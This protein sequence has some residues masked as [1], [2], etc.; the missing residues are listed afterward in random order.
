MRLN[1]PFETIIPNL[2]GFYGHKIELHQSMIDISSSFIAPEPKPGVDYAALAAEVPKIRA[3]LDYID[4]SA[5]QA[6]PLIFATLIDQKA[7]SKNHA[8]HLIITKAE[9]AELVGDITRNFG[10]KLDQKGQTFVV[11]AASVLKAHLLK[12]FKS[13]DD[14]WE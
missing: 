5:F 12:D 3:A 1:P 9:R 4:E 6:T 14:P 2:T 8:S 11:S 7:D 13:S 10:S